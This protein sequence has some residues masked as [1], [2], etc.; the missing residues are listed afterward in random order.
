MRKLFLLLLL[1]G[2][3]VSHVNKYSNSRDST[4]HDSTY[5]ASKVA[6]DST[7]KSVH[8]STEKVSTHIPEYL[9]GTPLG[10]FYDSLNVKQ[11]LNHLPLYLPGEVVTRYVHVHSAN[12]VIVSKL[13][14][15]IYVHINTTTLITKV[16]TK[17]KTTDTTILK[18]IGWAGVA[19][20]ILGALLFLWLKLRPSIIKSALKL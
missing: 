19:L 20:L 16:I 14:N 8:D 9:I 15:T 13:V 7:R 11:E 12:T 6:S 3:G 18:N 5:A 4:V 17:V 2:C 10:R 1:T